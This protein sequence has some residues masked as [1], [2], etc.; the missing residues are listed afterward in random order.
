M[1]AVPVT[2]ASRSRARLALQRFALGAAGLAATILM[3][4][5]ATF[6]LSSL[7]P[8]DPALRVVGDHASAGAYEQAR[9]DLGLDRPL[10]VRFLR[11]VQ[12]L[13][14]GD[15]GMS[16]ATGQ[17]VRDD[18]R[19]AIPATWELATCALI[20][21]A[22]LGFAAG[23][24]AAAR[25]GTW[26]DGA[27]RVVSLL[28]SAVPA[29]WLGL[30]LLYLFYARLQWAGGPGRLDDAFEYTIER[31]TGLVLVDAWLSGVPGALR[32]ACAHLVL[33]VAVLSANAVGTIARMSRTALLEEL[34][35]EYVTLARAKGAG[36]GRVLWGHVLPNVLGLLVVVLG[37]SYASLL[38]G[39]VLTETVFAWPGVGRYL[40][41]AIFAGDAAAILG[42]T[43]VIGLSFSLLNGLSDRL[44]RAADPRA[45]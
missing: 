37:L 4:L 31:R 39:A 20:T 23:V 17:P 6:A 38:E 14:K 30:L 28:G 15:L 42:A 21:S 18:L 45:R 1:S 5:A 12:Q 8:V 2:R 32:S 24:A 27:V 9:R 22:A 19:A 25:A 35:K 33:P 11:Y 16:T 13:A 44:A 43:L 10:P 7:S 40:T 26:V 36:E 41:T 29:F 34:G 3:L